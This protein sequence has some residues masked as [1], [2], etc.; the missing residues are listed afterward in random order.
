MTEIIIKRH[1]LIDDIASAAWVVA[2]VEEGKETPHRLHQTFDICQDGNLPLTERLIG[3]ALAEIELSLLPLLP[4]AEHRK[5]RKGV[6]NNLPEEIRVKLNIKSDR[7]KGAASRLLVVMHD[8]IVARVLEEWLSITLPASAPTWKR[9]AEEL[10]EI[11]SR[12]PSEEQR[13]Q[14]PAAFSRPCSPF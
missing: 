10:M 14:G 6:R 9:K 1:Q 13:W 11:I 2:D 4:G 12:L 5:L 8:Y 3:L 7:G